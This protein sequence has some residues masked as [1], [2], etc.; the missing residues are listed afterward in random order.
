VRDA[1]AVARA[2]P[3]AGVATCAVRLSPD[4]HPLTAVFT[5]NADFGPSASLPL[6]QI[7]RRP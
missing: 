4:V 1:G 3:H 2:G 5:G 6:A 7:V